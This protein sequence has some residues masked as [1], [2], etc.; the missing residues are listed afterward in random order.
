MVAAYWKKRCRLSSGPVVYCPGFHCCIWYLQK[1]HFLDY[2]NFGYHFF[3]G[4]NY[5]LMKYISVLWRLIAYGCLIAKFS[6][7]FLFTCSLWCWIGTIGCIC[8]VFGCLGPQLRCHFTCVSKENRL[9]IKLCCCHGGIIMHWMRHGVDEQGDWLKQYCIT[10]NL[11]YLCQIWIQKTLSINEFL[12]SWNYDRGGWN[13]H[14]RSMTYLQLGGK[15]I[16]KV[17]ITILISFIM[18]THGKCQYRYL[19]VPP[20][21]NRRPNVY[22]KV[23]IVFTVTDIFHTAW[24]N[25]ACTMNLQYPWA[26]ISGEPGRAD[27]SR[28]LP[29]AVKYKLPLPTA[30]R[31]T[32][33]RFIWYRLQHSAQ[34]NPHILHQQR[35]VGE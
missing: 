18:Q 10:D 12:D 29:F 23:Y 6:F 34:P 8:F 27:A 25:I 11:S 26:R 14:S 33:A 5:P 16:F 17:A 9:K 3:T 19:Y 31:T 20:L 15:C 24:G 32:F 7:M 22:N 28:D 4:Q 35:L 21:H 2:L 1:P 13:L 30:W